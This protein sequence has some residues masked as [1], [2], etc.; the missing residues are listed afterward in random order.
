M[1]EFQSVWAMTRCSVLLGFCTLGSVKPVSRRILPDIN[2]KIAKASR[3]FGALS[4]SAFNNNKDFRVETKYMQAC[5]HSVLL[6]MGLSVGQLS[7]KI[8][9]SSIPSTTDAFV[10]S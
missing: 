10:P 1:T 9:R 5:V 6:Y 4:K 3:S 2:Q 7:R 8:L